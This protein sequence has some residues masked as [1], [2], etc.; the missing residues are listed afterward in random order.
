MAHSDIHVSRSSFTRMAKEDNVDDV[1]PATVQIA[2]QLDG[3]GA[4]FLI[5]ISVWP[6]LLMT[7]C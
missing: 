4:N 5:S 3:S 2:G 7:E 6:K 1:L